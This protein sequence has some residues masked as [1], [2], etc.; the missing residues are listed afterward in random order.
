MLLLALAHRPPRVAVVTAAPAACAF[1]EC[2]AGKGTRERC[3]SRVDRLVLVK[4]STKLAVSRNGIRRRRCRIELAGAGEA[5][6]AGSGAAMADGRVPDGAAG[7]QGEADGERVGEGEEGGSPRSRARRRDA[8][9][10]L[11]ER[12]AGAPPRDQAL[13]R[14]A[15]RQY[16]VRALPWTRSARSRCSRKGRA[17]WTTRS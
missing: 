12:Q 2:V 14:V 6:P 15:E 1:S 16:T 9:R 7:R 13:R 4:I 5:A 3:E 8:P 17:W 11:R 10:R